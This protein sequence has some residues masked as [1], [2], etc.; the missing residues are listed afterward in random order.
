VSFMPENPPRY[1]GPAD[2]ARPQDESAQAINRMAQWQFNNAYE[3]EYAR[4]FR[5]AVADSTRITQALGLAKTPVADFG[6][7]SGYGSLATRLRV[8]SSVLPVFKAQGFKR[9]VFLVSWGQFDTHTNQRGADANT[10]DTQY[11]ALAKALAAFD[12]T[13]RANGLDMNVVTLMMSDFGRLGQ[14]LVRPGRPGGRRQRDRH[15]PQ[16]ATGRA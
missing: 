6:T 12:E 11:I 3:A 16:P 2:L 4:T 15:L 8:L 7:S 13:N 10:Q 1:W 14:P 5:G 9:Q